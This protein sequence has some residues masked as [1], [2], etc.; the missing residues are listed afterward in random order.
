MGNA[1]RRW[2]VRGGIPTLERGN[3]QNTVAN[4]AHLSQL[5]DAALADKASE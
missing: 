4:G 1:T 5:I 2:S 3:D